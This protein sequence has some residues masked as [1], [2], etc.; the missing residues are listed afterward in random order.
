MKKILLLGD[1]IRLSYCA[2]VR[3]LLDGKAEV[4]YPDDNC[5]YIKYTLRC[6]CD[7]MALASPA[8]DIVHWN[9]GL[10]DTGKVTHDGLCF[11]PIYEYAEY[12]DY[13]EKETL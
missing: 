8:P 10:W 4:F 11:T 13:L 6:L 9:N 5:R 1:S 7:W 12:V 2:R 3:E